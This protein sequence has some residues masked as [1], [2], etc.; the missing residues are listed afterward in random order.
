VTILYDRGN[1]VLRSTV[2]AGRIPEPY[3]ALHP[4]TAAGIKIEGGARINVELDGNITTVVSRFDETVPRGIILVPRSMGIPIHTLTP[5]KIS[6]AE[7]DTEMA[8]T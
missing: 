7:P 4:D 1:T 8:R 6:L 5:I 2:L 3:V